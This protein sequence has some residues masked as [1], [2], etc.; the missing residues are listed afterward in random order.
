MG[1]ESRHKGIRPAVVLRYK[2]ERKEAAQQQA[3]AAA[4]TPAKQ[5]GSVDMA[6]VVHALPDEYK[7]AYQQM[8]PEMQRQVVEKLA[9]GGALQ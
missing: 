4:K 8:S 5:G 1:R 2:K 6:A 7:Q 9:Q 3:A